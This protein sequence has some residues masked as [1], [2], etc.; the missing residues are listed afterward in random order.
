[1]DKKTKYNVNDKKLLVKIIQEIKSGT[2]QPSPLRKVSIPKEKGGERTISI[3]TYQD[4]VVLTILKLIL[5][6]IYEPHFHYSSYGFR[7]NL[8]THDAIAE[9]KQYLGPARRY[10]WIIESDIQSCF[11]TIRKSRLVGILQERIADGNLLHLIRKYLNAGMAMEGYPN[12]SEQSKDRD[13]GCPQGSALSPLFCNIYLDKLDRFVND[14]IQ[15]E[16]EEIERNKPNL[17]QEPANIRRRRSYIG[18]KRR[19][20]RTGPFHLIRYADDLVIVSAAK[21]ENV[22]KYLETVREFAWKD[23]GLK[24]APNKTQ[25]SHARDGF[26]FLGFHL[27]RIYRKDLKRNI[28]LVTVDPERKERHRKKIRELLKGGHDREVGAMIQATN[29]RIRGWRNYYQK[30]VTNCEELTYID[31]LI[32]WLWIKWLMKKFKSGISKIFKTFYKRVYINGHNFK[33]L[34]WKKQYLERACWALPKHEMDYTHRHKHPWTS[35]GRPQDM[36]N[37]SF[38]IQPRAPTWQGRGGY[39]ENYVKMMRKALERDHYK[40]NKCDAKENLHVHHIN[41]RNSFQNPRSRP[42]NSL[43]NLVTLCRTCH[44]FA[45]RL[46][47]IDCLNWLLAD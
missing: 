12:D 9:I 19:K 31:Q 13:C 5:E 44:K 16:Q 29:Q 1:M 38:P 45:N 33:T 3:P 8:C 26:N 15:R 30:S 22:E 23:L 6:P 17:S 28:I 4:R 36:P 43:E 21:R 34:L 37:E 11:D 20:Q 32:F 18:Q 41:K 40:C 2:I 42:A 47:A 25:I 39:G 24:L 7:P 35:G 10:A 46:N 14:D 27:K